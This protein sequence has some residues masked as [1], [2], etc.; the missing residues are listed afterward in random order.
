MKR[1]N[2]WKIVSTGLSLAVMV[3]FSACQE[4]SEGVTSSA[5]E[6]DAIALD[7]A[8]ADDLFEDIDLLSDEAADFE[9]DSSGG[10]LENE[11]TTLMSDCVGRGVE[12]QR[13]EGVFTK[14]VTLDFQE[15]CEGPKGRERKGTMIITRVTDTNESTYTVSTTLQNFYLDG[16]KVEGTRTR[17]Y[18]TLEPGVQQVQIT[19]ADGKVTLEDGQV[20]ER[21]GSFTKTWNRDSGETTVEGSATGI[22]R[23]GVSYTSTITEPL[24]Y[25]R[26]CRVDGVF[27]AVDGIRNITRE[28]K[29]DVT[30][31]YGDGECDKTVDVTVD[32]ETRSVEMTITRKD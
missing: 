3:S 16:K 17:V 18:T 8:V 22:N 12:R 4:D 9:G 10:R 24:M 23:N 14:T 26:N 25:K 15:G 13:V 29:A 30:V 21:D 20:I 11:E 28:G 6:A 19:L 7:E 27:M 5:D 32:G 31:D 2:D 1:I